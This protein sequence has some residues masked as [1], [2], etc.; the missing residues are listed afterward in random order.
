MSRIE[1]LGIPFDA[2]SRSEACGRIF[3]ACRA[4]AE[5]PFL[6]VTPNPVM[7][8]NAAADP[9]LRTALSGAELSL[10]DGIGI[11][12]AAKRAGKP[13]PERVTG[14]DTGREV[15]AMLAESGGGVY[16]LGGEPGVAEL[17]AEE[18][19][20]QLPSL[21]IVGT[22]HGFFD[23]SAQ[24]ISDINE[25][26]P[27]LLIL[28]L[29]SPRQELWGFENREHLGGVGAIMCLGGALDIWSG[30]KRRAPALFIKMRL[31]WL[32][33]MLCE[34]KRASSLPKMLKFRLLTR[35]SRQKPIRKR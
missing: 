21:R 30:K 35:K 19:R 14:I 15:M 3:D 26:A 23:N 16:L 32:W 1:I 31:E 22:H 34:P 8:M 28:C 5:R 13:L 33:R 25:K 4:R 7:V 12:S 11:V 29:G 17:A 9:A 6:V 10:A 2:V 24:L 18:L 20:L 27:A